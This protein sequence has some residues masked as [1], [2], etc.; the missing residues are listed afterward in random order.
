MAS[1]IAAW[2]S[3]LAIMRREL[4]L[5]LWLSFSILAVAVLSKE[6]ARDDVEKHETASVAW[7]CV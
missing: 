5:L 1:S 2:M 7:D 3:L 6:L 4:P